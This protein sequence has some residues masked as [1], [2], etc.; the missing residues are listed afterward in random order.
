MGV[1]GIFYSITD[2]MGFV[3]KQSIMNHLGVSINPVEEFHPA[4]YVC[5]W[6]I[7]HC[8]W[9]G[10]SPVCN[11]LLTLHVWNIETGGN[12]CTSV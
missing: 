12:S 4:T 1:F 9:Y 3:S 11:I 10:Y 6:K 8:I 2:K 5:R 7:G